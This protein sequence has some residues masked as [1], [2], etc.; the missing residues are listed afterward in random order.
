MVN[1][2][3][4][5]TNKFFVALVIILFVNLPLISALEISNVQTDDVTDRSAEVT[6]DTDEP[7]DSFVIYGEDKENLQKNGNAKEVTDHQ[8]L[9]GNLQPG[10]KHYYKVESGDVVDDNSGNFYS[11]ETL[12]P[13]VTPPELVVEIPEL[14]AGTKFELSGWTEPGAEVKLYVDGA[15]SAT[16]IALKEEDLG[17]SFGIAAEEEV[18]EDAVE[19]ETSATEE[20]IETEESVEA[21]V[22]EA[23]IEPASEE[24]VEEAAVEPETDEA[25]VGQAFG[26]GENVPEGKFVFSNVIIGKDKKTSIKIEA[27]DIAGNKAESSGQ[28]FSDSSK[29]KLTFTAL[30]EIAVDNSFKL[31]ATISEESTYEIFVNNNSVAKGDGLKIEETISF[32][33]GD[34][35]LRIVVKDAAGWETVKEHTV[36]SDTQ[37]PQVSFEIEKGNEYYQGKMLTPGGGYKNKAQSSIHGETEPGA[38]VYLYVYRPL[39]NEYKPDFKKAYAK[40]TAGK[41]GTFTFKD[42]DFESESHSLEDL[43]PKQVPA[44]LLDY[45][46]SGL[47][48]AAD[49]ERISYYVFVVAEDKVGRS[50]SAQTTV[51]INTCY[52]NDFDFDIQSLARFQRPLRLNPTLLDSGRE[53]ATAVFN[54]S[55]RGTGVKK[56]DYTTGVELQEAFEV[57]SVS[58]DR[59]CTR[60]MIE[61]ESSELG[62]VIMPPTIKGLPNADKTA[63]Y[64]TFNLHTAEKLS[65]TEGD[66]WNEFKKRQ[67]VFPLKVR[68]S[69]RERDSNG[70]F[71]QT[72]TQTSCFDLSYFID[73]PVDSK[74][75]LPDWLADEGVTA[76]R[77]T[78]DTIDKVL[79]YLQ[80]AILIAGVSCIGSFLLRMIVRWSRLFVSKTES[81]AA[82]VKKVADTAT[83]DGGEEQCPIPS[84][85]SKLLL[86]STID[87][88]DEIS[89]ILNPTNNR[90]SVITDGTYGHE[91]AAWNSKDYTLDKLCPKTAGLWKAEA[92]LDQAYRWTCDR[93]FCRKVPAGWTSTKT[94]AEIQT[95]IVKQNQC[96]IS[97]QGIPLQEVENCQEVLEANSNPT[98]SSAILN[99]REKGITT[100]YRFNERLYILSGISER[101]SEGAEIVYLDLIKRFGQKLN[102]ATIYSIPERLMAY[103]P[104]GSENFIVGQDRTCE[105]ACRNDRRPGYSYAKSSSVSNIANEQQGSQQNGCYE[106]I[107]TTDGIALRGE[108]NGKKRLMG[109]KPKD[110]GET[111]EDG[112]PKTQISQ[113]SAGYTS[114]CFINLKPSTGKPEDFVGNKALGDTCSNTAECPNG[115]RCIGGECQ[116]ETSNNPL[117]ATKIEGDSTGMLQCVCD[118]VEDGK[119]QSGAR[120]AAREINDV[121]EDWIYRQDALF[122]ENNQRR[123]TEYPTWRYY[124]G[125]DL[126]SAFGADY[127]IDYFRGEGKEEVATIDPHSQFVGRYQTLCLSGIRADLVMLK[128]ILEGLSGCIEEAKVTGLRDAGVCKT[129]FSQHV[130]GL[131]YKVL[132]YFFEDCSPIN[133]GD[134]TKSEGGVLDEIGFG[135]NAGFESI[136]ESMQSSINDIKSDYGNAKLNEFFATGVQGFTQSICMA[137][138]GYDWPLGM[139][140]ILDSAYAFQT[141]STVMAF[142]RERELAT[143]NPQ[144]GTAVF[145]YNLG[146]LVFPGCQIRSVRTYLKCVGPEDK[147]HPGIECGSQGCDCFHTTEVASAIESEKIKYLD[148]GRGLTNLRAGQMIDLEIPSPQKVDSNYRYDHVVVELQLDNNEN[149]ENCFDEG[150]K[151]GKFYFPLLDISPPAEFVCEVQIASGRYYCPEVQQLFGGGVT[152]YLEEPYFTCYDDKTQSWTNCKTPGLFTKGDE[153]RVKAHFNTDGGKYCLKTE[154]TGIPQL[155]QEKTIDLPVALPGPSAI[156]IFNLGTVGENLFSGSTASF[157][158]V[159][160]Q[161]SKGCSSPIIA[162]KSI[163]KSAESNIYNF[164]YKLNK[165]LYTVTVPKNVKVASPFILN[166]KILNKQLGPGNIK[167]SFNAKELLDVVFEFKGGFQYKNLIG[168]ASGAK[169]KCVYQVSK[170]LNFAKDERAITI[171][172]EVLQP[173]A[174]GGCLDASVPVRAPAFGKRKDSVNIVLQLQS[175]A[176][177]ETSKLHKLFMDDKCGDVLQQAGQ[178]L[179]EKKADLNDATN[180]YYATAC[181]ILAAEAAGDWRELSKGNV[182]NLLQLFFNRHYVGQNQYGVPYPQTVKDKTEFKKIEQ[183]LTEIQKEVQCE[184]I[185]IAGAEASSET[186]IEQSTPSPAAKINTCSHSGAKFTASGQASTWQP[187]GW[188]NY[189]CRQAAGTQK[190][191]PKSGKNLENSCWGRSDYSTDA[192]AKSLGVDWGCGTGSDLCCP[193]K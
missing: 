8:F 86:E 11:F 157:I 29:P 187:S 106:E 192:I 46:L 172:S 16:S 100:C 81:Y 122:K 130:C 141:K 191:N 129:V 58:F 67:V 87:H 5:R 153:I 113:F 121:A 42:V 49:Q 20:A 10:K 80:D 7:A 13:D 193:P 69:Y 95:V 158:S 65:E 44:E 110:S 147:G 107:Q 66:F 155:K 101:T 88:W 131:M 115:A 128:S 135:F 39:G 62:C 175:S 25:I 124:S 36:Y 170:P 112:T 174:G 93:V 70:K 55:Y 57:T 139:D 37:A 74:D 3:T 134:Q 188:D 61:D 43:A 140:F 31:E 184:S 50:G 181:H 126:S 117:V 189:V 120:Q 34:N 152:G 123:G 171:T 137:A 45:T 14:V 71:G 68:V 89:G 99:I 18:V 77:S 182:C 64:T 35:I 176:S 54:L 162:G 136:G 32:E 76:I 51:S 169:G 28:V 116:S 111:N 40:V 168:A 47:E 22:E 75:M 163:P 59:A 24:S 138:F 105:S 38:T 144:K 166:G 167:S 72:K 179:G 127:L 2:K 41:N 154:V 161:T 125:R 156:E 90:L 53:E 143:F 27:F 159:T 23:A 118:F 79:P 92:A 190:A 19:P 149:S 133:M 142:P 30:P 97:A 12:P 146:V 119:P 21:P 102:A 78:I 84:E 177:Q 60:E 132:A 108:L 160:S 114:D 82:T 180:I 183:Y 48:K 1:N 52:S 186:S 148:Q 96:T 94:E 165:G 4:N 185:N 109:E 33:E 9:L 150:Y 15:L 151:D 91:S 17:K 145:N 104:K 178:N 173:N 98:D 73:I 103:R 85:Q 83:G 164:N 56:I 6:W 63:W 26:F